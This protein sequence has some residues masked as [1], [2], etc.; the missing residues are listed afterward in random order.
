MAN[1]KNFSNFVSI[2]HNMLTSFLILLLVPLKYF[3][4]HILIQFINTWLLIF[5]TSE[6]CAMYWAIEEMVQRDKRR[7]IWHT[8]N[9]T[10]P[11]FNVRRYSHLPTGFVIHV[12]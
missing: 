4:H 12:M 2:H 9:G 11:L 10:T 3:L 5:G 7:N 6:E 8:N 1:I